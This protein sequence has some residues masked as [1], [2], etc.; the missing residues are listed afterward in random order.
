MTITLLYSAY[1][2]V[3]EADLNNPDK[4][5]YSRAEAGFFN[6]IHRAFTAYTGSSQLRGIVLLLEQAGLAVH[7]ETS[8]LCLLLPVDV[9]TASSKKNKQTAIGKG[10]D[11]DRAFGAVD[12]EMVAVQTRSRCGELVSA[13]FI[14][15]IDGEDGLEDIFGRHLAFL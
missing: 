14:D 12:E 15:K 8:G 5:R 4:P 7:A 1:V 13:A 6:A 3:N 11:A 9:V 2:K 10:A